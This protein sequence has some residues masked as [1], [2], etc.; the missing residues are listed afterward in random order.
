MNFLLRI[1]LC[2]LATRRENAI[3]WMIAE[4]LLGYFWV[5]VECIHIG[6]GDGVHRSISARLRSSSG[7][8][9]LWS[10]VYNEEKDELRWEEE[11]Q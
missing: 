3:T 10:V 9:Y 6:G 4:M 7:G 8:I 11:I 2:A 1:F 5:V